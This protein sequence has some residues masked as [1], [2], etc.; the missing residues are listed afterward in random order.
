MRSHVLHS[1]VR[2]PVLTEFRLGYP[3]DGWAPQRAPSMSLQEWDLPLGQL[4][5][6]H[7]PNLYLDPHDCA[8]LFQE[9][10]QLVECVICLDDFF[11]RSM[12]DLREQGIIDDDE[13]MAVLPMLRRLDITCRVMNLFPWCYLKMPH[14][15]ELS[16]TGVADYPQRIKEWRQSHFMAFCARSQFHLNL[17]TLRLRFDFSI[18]P[19]DIIDIL[20]VCPLLHSLELRW[21]HLHPDNRPPAEKIADLLHRMMPNPEFSMLVPH[22]QSIALD[23]TVQSLEMLRSRRQSSS[24]LSKIVLYLQ[25]DESS[26]LN[27]G[28]GIRALQ[29]LGETGVSFERMD[30]YGAEDHRDEETV[31]LKNW[32]ETEYQQYFDSL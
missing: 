14:L 25:D 32:F 24:Q 19:S 13:P 9:G 21:T 26:V 27:E 31:R 29:E 1:K 6:L 30:F 18:Y 2:A 8:L 16:I 12:E 23:G 17:E 7:I 3:P 10:R 20:G 22:L 15:E 11:S 5:V 4:N 28:F